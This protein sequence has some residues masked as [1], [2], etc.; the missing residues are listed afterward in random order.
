MSDDAA[1]E[2]SLMRDVLHP[3]GVLGVSYFSR[4]VWQEELQALMAAQNT[5]HNPASFSADSSHILQSYLNL[6]GLSAYAEDSQLFAFFTPP[7]DEAAASGGAGSSRSARRV[8]HKAE[9]TQWASDCG[10]AVAAALPAVTHN[11][12]SAL[13]SH[14]EVSLVQQLG[15]SEETFLHHY[16]TSFRRVVFLLP[17]QPRSHG[18]GVSG[19]SVADRQP[20]VAAMS[21]R[22]L[23]SGGDGAWRVV[24]RHPS[25][26]AFLGMLFNTSQRVQCL[27]NELEMIFKTDSS[28]SFPV[29]YSIPPSILP[30][31]PRIS[32]GVTFASLLRDCEVYWENVRICLLYYCSSLSQACCL[33]VCLSLIVHPS[34]YCCMSACI[35]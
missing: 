20:S 3:D 14:Y 7:S 29:T 2:M 24:D 33:S 25:G 13:Q 9:I 21:R 6:R 12:F 31:L 34:I 22:L 26:A 35:L 30:A 4:S 15:L 8:F 27:A 19:A 17:K 16:M 11:P 28:S 10:Y 32:D 23:H 18:G 1:Q 5:S